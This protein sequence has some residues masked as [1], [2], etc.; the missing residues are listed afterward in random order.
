MGTLF[1]AG[2]LICAL[3][4]LLIR[5]AEASVATAEIPIEY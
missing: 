2:M 1:I 5:T 3:P 4:T